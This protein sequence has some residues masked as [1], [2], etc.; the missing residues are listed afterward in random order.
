MTVTLRPNDALRQYTGG[1]PEVQ[2]DPGRTV[3]ETLAALGI[4]SELVA[5]VVVNNNLQAKDY[6]LQDGDQVRVLAVIGGG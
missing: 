3:L 5:A 1:R 4:P 6:V 2:V